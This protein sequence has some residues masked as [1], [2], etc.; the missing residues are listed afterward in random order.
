MY[1]AFERLHSGPQQAIIFNSETNKAIKGPALGYCV[2]E[3]LLPSS[4]L[5]VHRNKPISN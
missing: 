1:H 3:L 2:R 5:S 4:H